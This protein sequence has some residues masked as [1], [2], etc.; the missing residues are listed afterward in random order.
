MPGEEEDTTVFSFAEWG[1][2]AAGKVVRTLGPG[3][4]VMI[5]GQSRSRLEWNGSG[6]TPSTASNVGLRL[7]A[8]LGSWV[9]ESTAYRWQWTPGGREGTSKGGRGVGREDGVP[10]QDWEHQQSGEGGGRAAVVMGTNSYPRGYTKLPPLK[11]REV[12]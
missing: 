7:R 4:E 3:T 1:W 12:F 2:Q 11:L 8:G 5:Q 6:E 10:E 9:S